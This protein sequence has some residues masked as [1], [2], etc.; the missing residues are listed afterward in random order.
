VPGAQ[1]HP[2]GHPQD[3]E[4]ERPSGKAD[5]DRAVAGGVDRGRQAH[6]QRGHHPPVPG[7]QHRQVD[8][9]SLALADLCKRL[10]R[11]IGSNLLAHGASSCLVAST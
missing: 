10:G 7:G 11:L 1:H 4:R 6:H 2:A 8:D 5:H 3:A 9:L